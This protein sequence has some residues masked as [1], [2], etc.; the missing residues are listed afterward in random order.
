MLW[1]LEVRE[2]TQPALVRIL[3]STGVLKEFF[4]YKKANEC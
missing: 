2:R 1:W 3:D 4:L